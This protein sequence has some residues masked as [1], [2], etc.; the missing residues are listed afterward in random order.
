[1]NRIGGSNAE[2]NT[3]LEVLEKSVRLPVRGMRIQQPNLGT[4]EMPMTH[5]STAAFLLASV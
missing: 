5:Q 1:V 3:N 4:A 2:G